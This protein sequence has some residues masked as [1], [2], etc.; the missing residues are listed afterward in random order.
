MISHRRLL[1][2]TVQNRE[3]S[4]FRERLCESLHRATPDKHVYLSSLDRPSA[5]RFR[6][7]QQ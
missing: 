1:T 6:S 4:A 3:S 2:G 5:L 7:H